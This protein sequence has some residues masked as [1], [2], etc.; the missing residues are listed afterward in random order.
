MKQM[1][2]SIGGGTHYRATT[3]S[4]MPQHMPHIDIDKEIKPDPIQR[5]KQ[6]TA[7]IGGG[8]HYT[9]TTT[10]HMLMLIKK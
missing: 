7:C 5:M 4:H 8:K 1:T 6:M 10:S 2:A 9:A 3:T